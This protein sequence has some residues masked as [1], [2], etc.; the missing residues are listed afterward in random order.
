[1]A[2]T[3]IFDIPTTCPKQA[4]EE[5]AVN[6]ADVVLE[7]EEDVSDVD[8]MEDVISD[9]FEKTHTLCAAFTVISLVLLFLVEF[10]IMAIYLVLS[11]GRF[12]I[13][14]TISKAKATIDLES[15]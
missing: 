2:L 9:D 7:T 6:T 1:M 12:N 8:A 4:F 5:D 3:K 11:N 10:L 13:N 14:V 15:S